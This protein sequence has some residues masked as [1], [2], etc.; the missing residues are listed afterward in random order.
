MKLLKKG[1]TVAACLI[2]SL[3]LAACGTNGAKGT[4][5]GSQ[6][7]PKTNSSP[8]SVDKPVVTANTSD[9]AKTASTA[10]TDKKDVFTY[11]LSTETYTE[12]GVTVKFPQLIKTNNTAKADAVNKAIQETVK[13][14]IVSLRSEE[15]NVG[16]LTLDLDSQTAGYGGKV[17]SVSYQGYAHYKQSASPVNVY[18]TQNIDLGEDVHTLS[19][20]ELFNINDHFID[21]FKAGSYTTSR[22]DLN[23]EKSGVDVKAV[24]E[25]YSNQELADMFNSDNAKYQLTNTGVILSIEVPHA[26]GDH[27]EMTVNYDVLKA[28][29]VKSSQVWNS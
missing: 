15:N 7:V 14:I 11:S 22:K 25:Q 23:L 10:G 28:N 18:Y 24:I 26:L 12:T 6:T 19:L 17:F 20:K 29:M 8:K 5:A 2:L 9:T 21:C 13:E 16:A 27:L 3:S 4:A 1:M